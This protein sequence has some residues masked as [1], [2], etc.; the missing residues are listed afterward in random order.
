MDPMVWAGRGA[1][2]L[3]VDRLVFSPNLRPEI[4]FPLSAI[5]GPSV[6]KHNFF[7]FYSGRKVYRVKFRDNTIS[8]RKYAVALDILAKLKEETELSENGGAAL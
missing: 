5:D 8:G 2:S 1:I 7:E 4:V 6:L 3:Y